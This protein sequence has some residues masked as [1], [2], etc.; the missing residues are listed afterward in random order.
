LVGKRPFSLSHVSQLPETCGKELIAA[1]RANFIKRKVLQLGVAQPDA[2]SS[3]APFL[4]RT[5]ADLGLAVAVRPWFASGRMPLA[6][7]EHNLWP[8]QAFGG[9]R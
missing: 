8:V 6:A 5:K 1:V 3:V 7:K 4:R 9:E 2:F